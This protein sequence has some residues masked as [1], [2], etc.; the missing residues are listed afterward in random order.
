VGG[1]I[2]H[3]I[4]EEEDESQLVLRAGRLTTAQRTV[5]D[6]SL[7]MSEGRVR[8]LESG[9]AVPAGAEVLDFGPD[10]VIVPAG[11]D[12]FAWIGLENGPPAA[13]GSRVR[14]SSAIETDH[15][16]LGRALAAGVTTT[17]A[18]PWTA[19]PLRGRAEFVS[20]AL[21]PV[22]EEL[23]RRRR[24]LEVLRGPPAPFVFWL[25]GGPAD[26]GAR[27][28]R[29]KALTGL[30]R[31]AKGY[32][33]A[34]SKFEKKDEKK[35]P[36][37]K[38]GR[39]AKSPRTT[40][41]LSDP[42]NHPGRDGGNAA[43]QGG[44]KKKAG[45]AKK[46][47]EKSPDLEPWRDLFR[48]RAKAI[49][50]AGRHDSIRDALK[51]FGGVGVTPVLL[52]G[53]EADLVAGELAK[54]KVAVILRPNLTRV[55]EGETVLIAAALRQAGVRVAFGSQELGAADRLPLLAADAVRLGLSPSDAL[56]ALTLD[57][58]ATVGAAQGLGRL[59][60]GDRADCVVY[61]G[62]PLEPASRV[63]AVVVRGR[64]VH[65]W[66]DDLSGLRQ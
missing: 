6:V 55:H 16:S 8:G 40:V 65:Q 39:K 27:S 20:T 58:A 15:P 10:A 42:R 36:D 60:V 64:L 44:G 21:L 41:R 62:D 25:D 37:A 46:A 43:P 2:R 51:A 53:E 50:R 24:S 49:V 4:D 52:G 54:A 29:T 9:T 59:A 11:I 48:G 13:G 14:A 17:L 57:A 34:W 26:T 1:E 19:G 66:G 47:P 3:A 35:K 7:V 22:D 18:G 63:L 61:S 31:K 28:G 23:G 12:A 32:H 33:D 30:L 5:R 45:Q 38:A 56:R